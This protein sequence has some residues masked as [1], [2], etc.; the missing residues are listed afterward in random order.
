MRVTE[1]LIAPRQPACP[2]IVRLRDT[3]TGHFLP[4]D[5]IIRN[6]SPR[7]RS[8]IR[9]AVPP[10]IAALSKADLIALV[11]R[12]ERDADWHGLPSSFGMAP[13]PARVAR[14]AAMQQARVAQT[15]L[16]V[17]QAL[18]RF[19]ARQE[20][21]SAKRMAEEVSKLLAHDITGRTMRR[22]P[23]ASIW[24]RPTVELPE[25]PCQLMKKFNRLSVT[26]LRFRWKALRRDIADVREALRLSLIAQ[27]DEE[28]WDAIS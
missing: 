3:K 12:L 23:Y 19:A 10:H 16:C 9:C 6:E 13:P 22:E 18:V 1:V 25:P 26:Q 15:L 21:P 7:S 24:R 14:A 11:I 27:S 8:R 28:G 17:E 20:R 4:K 2:P 5:G